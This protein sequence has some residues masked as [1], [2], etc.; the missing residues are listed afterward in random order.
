MVK[1]IKNSIIR[2]VLSMLPLIQFPRLNVYLNR[3]LGYE[4]HNSVRIYSSVQ[5]RG[6]MKVVIGAGTFIGHETHI[7]GGGAATIMIGSNCDISDR[8]GIICGTHEIDDTGVRSAGNGIGKDINIGNGVWIGYG[9][10][11]L[12]GV[13]IGEKAIVAAGA[14]VTKDVLPRTIVGGSPAKLIRSL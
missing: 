5:I 1:G 11:I 12:P 7:T 3:L 10:L 4:L 14:V 8:V 9:A 2:S 6:S 13:S